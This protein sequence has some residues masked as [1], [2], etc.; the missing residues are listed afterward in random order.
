MKKLYI[1]A[2]CLLLVLSLAACV[3]TGEIQS[4]N[5]PTEAKPEPTESEPTKA[6]DDPS[7]PP[8]ATGG[9][10]TV[11]EEQWESD[12][13][14]PESGTEPVQKPTEPDAPVVTE[15]EVTEP[16]ETEPTAP[17]ETL[18]PTDEENFQRPMVKP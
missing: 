4:P 8:E 6:P 12:I 2:L 9:L 16:V 15:P 11:D 14:T 3:D 17:E 5:K 7:E 1:V 10:P 13:D 18:S